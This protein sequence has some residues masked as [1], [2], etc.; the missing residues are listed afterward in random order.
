[1]KLENQVAIV[2]G[3]GGGLGEGIC[4]RLAR[5]GAD[6]VV[7]DI[8]LGLAEKVAAGVR[9]MG[10]KALAVKTDVSKA[11]DCRTLIDRTLEVMG[12]LDVLVCGAGVMGYAHR[13]GKDEPLAIENM[14]EADWDLVQGVNLKGVFLC[15]RAAAP[16]FKAQKRGRIVNIAS[17]A[18][19]Q[20]VGDFLF[21]YA[22]SKA[23]VISLGQS[24]AL[25]FAPYNVNVNTVCPGI[26]WTPMWAEGVSVLKSANPGLRQADDQ[27]VFMNVVMNQIPL[28][29]VQLPEDIGNAVVFLVSDEAKEITGQALNVCGGMRMN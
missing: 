21:H 7:S 22:A 27:T 5:E 16:H 6:V 8:Q 15:V 13:G 17:V 28:K 4:L 9:E 2:T 11:A 24:L 20:G 12:R 23:G 3:G 1:M 18:G 19:R 10:R 26:I 25:Q 29:R 14:L